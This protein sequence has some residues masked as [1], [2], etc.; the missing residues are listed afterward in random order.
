MTRS[1]PSAAGAARSARYAGPLIAVAAFAGTAVLAVALTQSQHAVLSLPDRVVR[2]VAAVGRCTTTELDSW[3]GMAA[4]SRPSGVAPAKVGYPAYYT[5]EFTNV[6]RRTCFLSGY[7][8]VWAYMGAQQIGSPATL[9]TSIR[10][11]V[12]TLA[13]GATAHATLRYTGTGGFQA[14]ACRQVTASELRIDP[15]NLH[16]PVLIPW[17]GSACSRQGPRFLSVQ[18]VEARPGIPGKL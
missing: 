3:V 18:P 12:V 7:P 4:D 10:P 15:P 16:D 1:A 13:P 8:G 17:L 9:D 14:A 6:S 11:V 5:L 2:N